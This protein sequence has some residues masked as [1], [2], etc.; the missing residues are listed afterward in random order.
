MKAE[1][2]FCEKCGNLYFDSK[3]ST[4]HIGD[5][6]V[7]CLQG[8]FIGTGVD[9]HEASKIVEEE[10]E[11]TNKTYPSMQEIDELLRKKY[12]YGKLDQ[13]SSQSAISARKQAESPE[14]IEEANRRWIQQGKE[15]A[16]PKC[17]I[18]GSTNLKKLSVFGKVAKVKMFGIFGAGDLGKTYKCESCGVKF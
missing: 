11:T 3:D 7:K 5:I 17:P 6:C 18:C 16:G 15:S 4:N 13:Q 9:Y 1:L 14:V 8:K 10:Y 12:F 2:I